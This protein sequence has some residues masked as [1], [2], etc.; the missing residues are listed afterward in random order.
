M[1]APPVRATQSRAAQGGLGATVRP[2]FRRASRTA[3]RFP[4]G[5]IAAYGPNNALATKLVVSVIERPG[6]RDPSATRIWTTDTADVRHDRR[7]SA[8]VAR[9]LQEQDVQETV[10]SDRIIGC[11]HEEGI[12][13][14][15]G[16]SCPRCPFWAGIDRFT[17][18]PL[19][20]PPPTLSPS[21]V[22]D[23]LSS[24][25]SEPPR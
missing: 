16:R 7:I 8:E 4:V 3:T 23:A 21:Q 2:S 12:D 19:T 17:H 10:T 18:E 9:F 24:D 6:A 5:T 25:P 15:L 20:P 13:Y 14:P 22:L 1:D 11:P